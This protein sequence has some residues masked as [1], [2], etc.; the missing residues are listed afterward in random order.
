METVTVGGDTL[1]YRVTSEK[2][3]GAL[4]AFE[5]VMAPG[6]GPPALHRHDAFEL[7]RVDA[8]AFTFYL[9][10]EAGRVAATTAGPGSV[11]SIPGGREH[12]IR[13]ESGHEAR[14]L[15]VFS[16]GA[17]MERFT[18]GAG[19]LAASGEPQVSEVMSLAAEHGIELTRG[20]EEVA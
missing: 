18:R 4:L 11:V 17:A 13:N 1:T 15:V 12:T 3:G 6:G 8:G 16:P 14:A 19:A 2:S 20:V 7:Y 9:E 5:V 10:D